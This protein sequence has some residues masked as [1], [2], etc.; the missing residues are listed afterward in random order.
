MSE[1]FMGMYTGGCAC[2]RVR[3]QVTAPPRAAFN[4]HCRACQRYTGS[5]CM[6]AMIVPAEAFALT[7]GEPTQYVTQGD[8]GYEITRCFCGHC[9]S[10]VM[11]RLARVPDAVG[12]PAASLDDPSGFKP[13]MDVYTAFAQPWAPMN[14]DLRK[15]ETQPSRR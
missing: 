2:G 11:T 7:L 3:Y 9:G 14:P 15:F 4:C 1:P 10:P 13:T 8:S 12:V 6:S 5:A